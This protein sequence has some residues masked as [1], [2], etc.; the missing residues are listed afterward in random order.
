MLKPIRRKF[1]SGYIT[2]IAYIKGQKRLI[3]SVSAVIQSAHQAQF[4]FNSKVI[5]IFVFNRFKST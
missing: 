3:N 5:R 2:P 4:V 1:T